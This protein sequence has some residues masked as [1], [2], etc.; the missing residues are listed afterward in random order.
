LKQTSPLKIGS[1]C[2]SAN[3]HEGV[4]HRQAP[5]T[6]RENV[7]DQKYVDGDVF[8]VLQSRE[9]LPPRIFAVVCSLRHPY[10]YVSGLTA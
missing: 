2:G 1:H 5:A 9:I 8:P 3:L 7:E 10:P 6:D 4:R